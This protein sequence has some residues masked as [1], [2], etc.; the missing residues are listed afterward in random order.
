[1]VPGST[2]Q[3]SPVRHVTVFQH[4]PRALGRDANPLCRR[5][6]RAH[7]R[8]VVA[9]ALVLVLAGGVALLAA[10]TV[11]RSEQADTQHRHRVTATTLVAAPPA[12]GVLGA[13]AVQTEAGWTFPASVGVTGTIDV[14]PGTPRGTAVTTWV[15]D[16][17]RPA[18][19]RGAGEM[20]TDAALA[21]FLGMAAL[22]ATAFTLYAARR[23]QLDHRAEQSWEP[24]WAS[25]EPLWSGRAGHPPKQ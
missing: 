22:S 20:A 18:S 8:L 13:N 19:H 15:D 4:L 25:V 2:P 11:L 1:M 12:S 9:L 16:H 6:D 24:E 21:G 10:R 7:S 14:P 17:G 23:R 3:P 5:T